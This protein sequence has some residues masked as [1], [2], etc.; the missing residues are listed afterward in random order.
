VAEKR[1]SL[2]VFSG[3]SERSFPAVFLQSKPIF[4]LFSTGIETGGFAGFLGMVQDI[5][6]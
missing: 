6:W 5:L 1:L 4:G 3:N 2:W